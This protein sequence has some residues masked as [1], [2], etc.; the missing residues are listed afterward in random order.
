M[1]PENQALTSTRQHWGAWSSDQQ[2][3]PPF[4]AAPTTLSQPGIYLLDR[5]NLTQTEIRCGH[6]GPPRHTPDFFPLRLAN[7]IFGGGGFSSRLMMRLR[8][9]KGLTYGVR[10]QFHLRRAPGPF[11]IS[12]F[13]PAEHTAAVIQEI[14]DVMTEV[15]NNGASAAELADAQSYYVGSFPLSLETP[16]GLARQLLSID[17]YDLGL[18]Y[19]NLYRERLLAVD[20]TAL[21]ATAKK[22]LHPEGL[23][24]L[25]VG[26][27]ATCLDALGKL[28][29]VQVLPEVQ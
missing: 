24:T 14:R 9:E 21:Q 25:V 29:Q 5:P 28:G 22:Y 18:D 16:G 7:Y 13:T 3:A 12:T 4:Q 10:S 27:A 8:A 15:K 23:V 26:P 2:P 1:V 19:L 17:L 6:L 11:I 20:Q